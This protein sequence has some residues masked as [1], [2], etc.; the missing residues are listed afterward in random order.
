ML[1]LVSLEVV[2]DFVRFIHVF[3]GLGARIQTRETTDGLI[4]WLDPPFSRDFSANTQRKPV[5]FFFLFVFVCSNPLFFAWLKSPCVHLVSVCEIPMVDLHHG[6]APKQKSCFGKTAETSAVSRD[7]L[8]ENMA[9]FHRHLLKGTSVHRLP[10]MLWEDV[11]ICFNGTIV[12]IHGI[13]VVNHLWRVNHGNSSW[14]D[15]N[16]PIVEYVNQL[17]CGQHNGMNDHDW[18]SIPTIKHVDFWDGLLLGL[19]WVYH[20]KWYLVIFHNII[21]LMAQVWSM[22]LLEKCGFL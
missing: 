5:S 10:M 6:R 14:N 1:F 15:L 8:R 21:R 17:W 22:Y 3:I 19:Q 2:H 4:S 9:G 13:Y 18:V 7:F 12:A 16:V 20:I 11:L